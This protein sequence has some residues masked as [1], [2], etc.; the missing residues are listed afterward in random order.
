[1]SDSTSKWSRRN[2]LIILPLILSILIVIVLVMFKNGPERHKLTEISKPVRT[3]TIKPVVMVPRAIGYG[4]AEPSDVWKAI[5]QVSGN[6][7][8]TNPILKNGNLCKKGTF[9]AQIDPKEYQLAIVRM[10]ASIAEVEARL[11][12]LETEKK[13]LKLTLSIEE[14][15]LKLGKIE[16]DRQKKLYKKKIIPASTFESETQKYNSQLLKVQNIRNSINL[17]PSN[18]KQLLASLSLNKANLENARRDLANTIIKAPFNCRITDVQLQI[19]QFVQKGQVIITADGTE[20]AEIV[21]QIPTEKFFSMISSV[22]NNK[23]FSAFDLSKFRD[24]IGLSV[25]VKFKAGQYIA[26]WKGRFSRPDAA[27]DQKT[28]TAGIIVAVDNPY[29]KIIPGKRPPLVRNMYCEVELS[30][31]PQPN[32]IVIPRSSLHGNYVYLVDKD[33]RLIRRKVKKTASQTGFYVIKKGL[34]EGDRL[35]VSDIIPAIEGMLLKPIE[36]KGIEQNLE[37]EATGL[38]DIK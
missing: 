38:T 25:K 20:T 16:Y 37:A 30:G 35:I 23:N 7:I 26:V 13:N 8:K 32:T 34:D 6:I 19:S 17:V 1:M 29:E 2:L 21:A 28:R 31:K 5:A 4:K 22:A 10:E 24:K 9:L 3:I 12:E 36:D 15:S 18:K 14:N 33:S 11:S 27:L